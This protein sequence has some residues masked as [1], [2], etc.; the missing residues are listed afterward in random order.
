VNQ[1]ARFRRLNGLALYSFAT[2]VVLLLLATG[3]LLGP[4]LLSNSVTS[5]GWAVLPILLASG[6]YLAFARC[7]ECRN[8]FNRRG[9]LFDLSIRRCINCG[10][11][12]SGSPGPAA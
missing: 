12:P 7:P 9:A 3:L 4:G 8:P 2:S 10:F 1:V 6:L 11:R 5:I